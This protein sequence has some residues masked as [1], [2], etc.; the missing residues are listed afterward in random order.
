MTYSAPI[1]VNVEY[2]RGNQKVHSKNIV[3]GRMPIMLRSSRCVLSR[4]N[5]EKEMSHA[6]ECPN[7]PGGYFI[8]RGTEKVGKT[9]AL[10]TYN[11][12]HKILVLMHEQLSKNRIMINRNLKKEL[13]C[14][15]LSTSQDRKSKTYIINKRG[16]YYLRHNQ[17]ADDIPIAIIFKVYLIPVVSFLRE[18]DEFRQWAMNPTI[19]SCQFWELKRNL[20]QQWVLH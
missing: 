9:L 16:R 19:S 10:E 7:D 13:Y 3:I 11:K 14:E 6:N 20:W 18:N 1:Y 8:V 17:L 2:T 12:S 5:G 15:V 4:L